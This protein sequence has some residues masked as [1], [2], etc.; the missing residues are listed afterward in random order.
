[1]CGKIAILWYNFMNTT[2]L[3]PM[4]A[5]NPSNKPPEKQNAPKKAP[6]QTPTGKKLDKLSNDAA[7]AAMKARERSAKAKQLNQSANFR[8]NFFDKLANDPT[9]SPEEKEKFRNLALRS[10]GIRSEHAA[11]NKN[12][13]RT[14]KAIIAQQRVLDTSTN[15]QERQRKAA[16]IQ[17]L[18]AGEEG[19]AEIATKRAMMKSEFLR[20]KNISPESQVVREEFGRLDKDVQNQLLDA[21]SGR[22]AVT[23][24]QAETYNNREALQSDTVQKE[25]I[26]Y[27]SQNP[28]STA[29]INLG[30]VEYTIDP[31]S[32]A[33]IAGG[34]H[35]TDDKILGELGEEMGK[36]IE[37]AEQAGK[38]AYKGWAN[39]ISGIDPEILKTDKRN[40]LQALIMK[41]HSPFLTTEQR[42]E[43]EAEYKVR[44]AELRAAI[45]QRMANKYQNESDQ[46]MAHAEMEWNKELLMAAAALF[47]VGEVAGLVARPFT[48]AMQALFATMPGP[49]RA[50]F[51]NIGKAGAKEI[52][53]GPVLAWLKKKTGTEWALN[54]AGRGLT[55]TGEVVKGVGAAA[56]KAM[57]TLTKIPAASVELGKSSIA[58]LRR[59]GEKAGYK[60]RTS[61]VD[62]DVVL[63]LFQKAEKGG[64]ESAQKQ[65]AKYEAGLQKATTEK[66]NLEMVHFGKRIETLLA[67]NPEL[68]L[69]KLSS[70]ER[71]DLQEYWRWKIWSENP[72]AAST[73]EFKQVT[74]YLEQAAANNPQL[75]GKLAL[76]DFNTTARQLRAAVKLPDAVHDVIKNT[77]QSEVVKAALRVDEIEKQLT[78]LLPGSKMFKELTK[79]HAVLQKT[80][81]KLLKLAD[82]RPE[83]M[84]SV[85]SY[86]ALQQRLQRATKL[87]DA[88]Q[89]ADIQSQITAL[90][91]QFAELPQVVATLASKNKAFGDAVKSFTLEKSKLAEIWKINRIAQE[92]KP[93]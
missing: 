15:A 49:V 64:L 7:Y 24:V 91:T 68:K 69:S 40:K 60:F 52:N 42:A 78:T 4:T 2:F 51:L 36:R 66:N 80:Y 76:K 84:A 59:L 45:A 57:P 48:P 16:S 79:E 9:K 88:T 14:E 65:L 77:D 23:Y 56:E 20:N 41:M 34:K 50:A 47:P 25:A 53:A 55:K 83:A 71:T 92:F 87:R 85:E 90:E 30:N 63:S 73:P 26:I 13:H 46:E 32:G 3:C 37:Q 29:K 93:A 11:L 43:L 6:E 28:G 38:E 1:M 89:I 70:A 54:M 27:R 39:F 81:G 22:D 72:A 75:F 12:A 82:F 5:E 74:E 67:K 58:G 33:V 18:S 8:V 86:L 10:R 61:P 21:N 62:D 17:Q 35:V 44:S 31:D 19:K